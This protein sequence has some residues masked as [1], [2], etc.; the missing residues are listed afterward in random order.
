MVSGE[1]WQDIVARA[2]YES[3][4]Q[5]GILVDR[6]KTKELALHVFAEIDRISGPHLDIDRLVEAHKRH[7]VAHKRGGLSIEEIAAYNLS[8][9]HVAVCWIAE[10]LAKRQSASLVHALNQFRAL[11]LSTRAGLPG[12]AKEAVQRGFEIIDGLLED[13][14]H[15]VAPITEGYFTEGQVLRDLLAVPVGDLLNPMRVEYIHLLH[16]IVLMGV[17]DPRRCGTFRKT[18]VHVGDAD[19]LFPP[20]SLVPEMVNEFCREFPTILPTTV[21]YDPV[22][23]A[24]EASYE[25]VRIHPYHDGNGRVSR[26]LMNLV[27]WGHHP[28]VYL[29]ADKKGRH[30]YA[31][32]LKRANRGDMEPLGCLIAMAL[33]QIYEKLID[34]VGAR[35]EGGSR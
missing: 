6:G 33:A 15:P 12:D 21:K 5:E 24:A 35:E 10:E 29:K 19:V 3:N 27:L 13:N 32:A 9:A 8:A 23:K 18:P 25:F 26:L 7:V 31:Q 34:A 22:L 20:P 17:A 30:R 4:W 2:V 1:V 28:P 11:G 14:T 16:R